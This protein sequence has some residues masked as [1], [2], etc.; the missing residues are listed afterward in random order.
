MDGLND[1]IVMAKRATY[2][3]AAAKS[4]PY[5]LGT[6][7]L[8][9]RDGPWSYHD[10]YVGEGRLPRPGDRV[11]RSTT[12]VE[13]GLLRLPPRPEHIDAGQAGRTV[14]SALTSLYA[15]GRFLGGFV[16]DVGE[17]R[18]V[19]TNAGDVERF[20]GEEWIERGGRRVYE[21]RY[22]GGLVKF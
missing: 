7:D 13:H 20:S 10:S 14:Q 15:E 12:G 18:Y 21:L 2:A 3:A 22:F 11:P 5:R 9:F 4:L 19:D 17:Y 16:A 1:F 8:Q 6:S